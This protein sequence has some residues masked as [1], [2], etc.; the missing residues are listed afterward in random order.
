MAKK[1]EDQK[2]KFVMRREHLLSLEALI[3][4]S[5]TRRSQARHKKA[6]LQTIQPELELIRSDFKEVNDKYAEK[7]ENGLKTNEKGH[8][9]YKS[10]ED[11]QKAVKAF[12]EI[13]KE[14]ISITINKPAVV[15]FVKKKLQSELER[16]TEATDA[17]NEMFLE[18]CELFGLKVDED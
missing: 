2:D 10:I 12:D 18:L 13:G 1:T 3:N 6:F 14:P 4:N 5:L 16:D 7:D 8:I 17:D 9:I 11:L 15:E